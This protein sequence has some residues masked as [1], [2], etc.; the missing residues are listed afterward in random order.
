[1]AAT[2]SQGSY[3][4]VFL[5]GSTL[6]CGA[7]ATIGTGIGKLLLLAGAVAFLASLAGFLKIKPL[8]G[9]TPLERSPEAAKWMGAGVALLGWL[10][11][12]GGLRIVDGNGG[13]IAV[14]L[15]GIGVSL[16]G[17]LYVLPVVFNRTAFWKAGGKPSLT[18]VAGKTTV[19][20]FA[21]TSHA[22][23]SAR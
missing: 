12:I 5:L 16:F 19:E 11:T 3:F 14:A 15:L 1:M 22:M 9:K 23:E 10:V 17:I 6:L 4:G 13:R 2:R 7:V 20:S 8:E 21:A 18:P